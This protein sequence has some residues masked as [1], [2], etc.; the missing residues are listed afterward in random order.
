MSAAA[1]AVAR[2]LV[3]AQQMPRLPSAAM[4]GPTRACVCILLLLLISAIA[5]APG[6]TVAL[7]DITVAAVAPLALAPP[8]PPPPP[9]LPPLPSEMDALGRRV[10]R[11]EAAHANL[12][13]ALARLTAPRRAPR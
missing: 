2:Q 12:T 1:T 11:L 9:S 5:L 10:A 4:R 13:R 3:A 7:A 8:L 6:L